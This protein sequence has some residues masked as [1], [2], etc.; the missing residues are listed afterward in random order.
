M[1]RY[2]RRH[3]YRHYNYGH[4]RG[5]NWT[6]VEDDRLIQLHEDGVPLNQI[7][8]EL[9]RERDAI[10]YRLIKLGIDIN[11]PTVQKSREKSDRRLTEES[12]NS[13]KRTPLIIIAGVIVA[14]VVI[15]LFLNR[16]QI[17]GTSSYFSGLNGSSVSI[18]SA[19]S[20]YL[21]QDQLFAVYGIGSYGNISTGSKETVNGS[22][23]DSFI[24]GGTQLTSNFTIPSIAFTI[25]TSI[26]N[27]TID[28]SFLVGFRIRKDN[29]T[30]LLLR[31]QVISS[32]Q[33]SYIF[34]AQSQIATYDGYV[35]GMQYYTVNNTEV[36]ANKDNYVMLFKCV[37]VECTPKTLNATISAVS[38]D[39]I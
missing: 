23:L 6:S 36:I 7:A 15:F 12:E 35:N 16:S 37:G 19:S 34:F 22:S 3:R 8:I 4:T 28:K 2:H 11:Q 10:P 20:S 18:P 9:N 27:I 1:A 33:A 32:P 24:S 17:V 39:N 38:K 26:S 5:R 14:L 13:S 30:T 21:S 31:E 29:Q 25:N